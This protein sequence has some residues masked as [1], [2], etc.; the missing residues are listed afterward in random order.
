MKEE[1][2]RQV[3]KMRLADGNYFWIHDL[4]LKMVM[5][6]TR[7]DLN[8]KDIADFKDPKGKKLFAEM[9]QAVNASPT[10]EG[11]VDYM[12]GKPGKQ[13]EFPKISFVRLFKPWNWVIGMGVYTDDVQVAVDQE[14]TAFKGSMG[15]V[16]LLAGLSSLGL[17]VLLATLI[18]VYFRK[19]LIAPMHKL[20]DFSTHVA[21]GDLDASISGQ[22]VDELGV[23]KDAIQRMVE[24]LKGSL[25]MA[26]SCEMEAAN[27]A[28]NAEK[29]LARVQDGSASL[30]RLLDKMNTVAIKARE[31]SEEMGAAAGNL[32]VQFDAVSQGAETQKERIDV[33]LAATREMQSVVMDVAKNATEAAS[34][35]QSARARAEQG[36]AVVSEAVSAI[37][38]VREVTVTLKDSMAG[39]GRQAESIGQ[40]MN[41]INDI[42]DQTNLLALNAA[43][44][45][46][47]AGDAGRGFAVVADEVRKLAEKTMGATKEVGENIKAIQ[48]A[49]EQNIR[50]VDLAA[51]AVEQAT[52]Q[53]NL[54]GQ[55]LAEIV[56]IAARNAAQVD[57]IASAAE[58]QSAANEEIGKAVESVHEIAMH[59]VEDMARS[60]ESTR[61]MTELAE[62]IRHVI[63]KLKES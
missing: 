6:P 2:Q 50:N 1:A 40:V 9:N 28:R 58:Q 32:S 21:S 49:A 12:W 62:E 47:R 39:L 10:G 3:A 38:R 11:F 7:P 20:V 61:R 53:A 51:G 23:L 45:A 30:N 63:D 46:A 43:I 5:H 57:S 25:G 44:E 31:V 8:G 55:A 27:Q 41:V 4:G 29:L 59:T 33:T 16:L 54:S 19:K 13:G 15:R 24:S 48:S 26:K 36:A 17:T 34:S 42:A 22:F 37:R 14:R 35:A 56:D 18:L 52:E 60:S